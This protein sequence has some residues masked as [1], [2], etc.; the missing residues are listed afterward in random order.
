MKWWQS[1][2]KKQKNGKAEKQQN[3]GRIDEGMGKVRKITERRKE[4]GKIENSHNNGTSW[5][6][7]PLFGQTLE[8][9]RGGL[10]GVE[11]SGA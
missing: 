7:L 8:A 3:G 9:L 6:Y 4:G 5:H 10:E 2:N 1:K 11:T